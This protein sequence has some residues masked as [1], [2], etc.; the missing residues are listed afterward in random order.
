MEYF[1]NEKYLKE[2]F[3]KGKVSADR[4]TMEKVIS[5]TIADGSA[6]DMLVKVKIDLLKNIYFGKWNKKIVDDI[7]KEKRKP[8]KFNFIRDRVSKKVKK[9]R[10]TEYKK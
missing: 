10:V 4:Y 9:I 8:I 6:V 7:I 5:I 1:N 3:K 2:V